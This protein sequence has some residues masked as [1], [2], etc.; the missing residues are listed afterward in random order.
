MFKEGED[1]EKFILTFERQ[2]T[3][4]H[5]DQ[6]EWVM[7]LAESLSGLAH[8]VHSDQEAEVDY[9]TLKEAILQAY[10]VTATSSR[11]KL[12]QLKYNQRESFRQHVVHIKTLLQRWLKPPRQA[13]ENALEYMYY[14]R[15]EEHCDREL[16]MDF[17]I[18]NLSGELKTLLLNRN[19]RTV[20]EM[21]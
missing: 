12:H 20:E 9:E 21:V 19:P 17:A 8:D 18:A 13:G 2:M 11:I 10:G 7:A 14:R 16:M 3:R 15:W 1:I 4:A 5:I 6:A